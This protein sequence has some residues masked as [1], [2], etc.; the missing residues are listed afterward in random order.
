MVAAGVVYQIYPRSF[1]D[2]DGDGVGDLPGI[3]GRLDHVRD[4]GRRRH[5][6]VAVLPLADGRLRLRRLRLHRRRPDLRHARR[7]GRADRRGRT[8][9]G[10]RVLAR[11]G[12]QPHLGP[13]PLVRGVALVRSDP[14][15]D[16]YVWR[17]GRRRRPT[18]GSDAS[19]SSGPAWTRDERTGE[20]YLHSFLPEQPDLNWDEPEVEEAMHDVLRFW[21]RR[22]VD[23]FRIDVVHE[24]GKDPALGETSRVAATTRTGPRSTRACAAIRRVL[25]E[26]DGDR[27]AVGEVYVLD[28]R[29]LARYVTTGDELHLAHNFFFLDL[30]WSAPA[31]PGGGRRVRGPDARPAGWPAWCLNNHDHP[32]TATRYGH[33]RARVAAMLLLTLRGTPFLFQGRGAGA[34]GRPRARRAGRG[35]RRSRPRAAPMPWVPPSTQARSRRVQRRRAMAAGP[36][37]RRAARG[38]RCS[39]TTRTRRSSSTARCSPSGALSPPCERAPTA[40]SRRR[41]T[42]SRSSAST[43][44][45][46]SWWSST[47]RRFLDRCRRRQQAGDRCCST[48][49]RMLTPPSFGRTRAV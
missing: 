17:D 15:R 27:M 48:A 20:W 26:F 34:D 5:L 29:A 14:Q 44:A 23:G 7:R 32:R 33:E 16:W 18:T 28:Q 1:A 22:G 49:A 4:S 41:P 35:R 9:C 46:G 47:S 25:E 31:I 13:A 2:S 12:A 36:P 40:R 45:D 30:P 37:G 24:I 3:V 10:L 21:L 39:R 42:S 8:S 11:L 43:K 6:A 38:G 19:A